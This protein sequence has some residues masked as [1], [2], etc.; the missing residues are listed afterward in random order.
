M[1]VTS[2]RP[3][4]LVFKNCFLL[5]WM[6]AAVDPATRSLFCRHLVQSY[7]ATRLGSQNIIHAEGVIG[8]S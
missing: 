2:A 5:A 6:L 7:A 1:G 4:Y 3:L 8:K